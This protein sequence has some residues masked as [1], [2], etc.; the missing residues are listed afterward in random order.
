MARVAWSRPTRNGTTFSSFFQ[1]AGATIANAHH[2]AIFA[3]SDSAR[4]HEEHDE[5]NAAAMA[6]AEEDDDMDTVEVRVPTHK[7]LIHP[8]VQWCLDRG[9]KL[10]KWK[11][12]EPRPLVDAQMRVFAV[13]ADEECV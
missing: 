4:N 12:M 2:R 3:E 10:E 8:A 13:L 11:R 5:E 9:W 6:E 1:A 7:P